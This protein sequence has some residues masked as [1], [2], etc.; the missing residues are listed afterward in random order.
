MSPVRLSD[1]VSILA[2]CGTAD[3]AVPLTDELLDE[4]FYDLGYD[5]L[6]LLQ[7]ADRILARFAIQVP[8]EVL[9]LAETPRMLLELIDRCA[10][11]ALV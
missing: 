9:D 3:A 10:R 11:G 6:L 4:P 8:E 1:L 5:S 2:E 7:A